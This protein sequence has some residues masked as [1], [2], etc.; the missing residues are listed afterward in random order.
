MAKKCR[1]QKN[2]K[3]RRTLGGRGQGGVGYIH[4]DRKEKTIQKL[5]C[6]LQLTG[7]KITSFTPL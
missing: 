4:M 6:Q 1:M 7:D 3:G 2:G 5:F